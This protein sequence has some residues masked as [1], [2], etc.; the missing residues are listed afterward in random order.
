MKQTKLR[1]VLFVIGRM[2]RAALKKHAAVRRHAGN[3]QCVVQI[4]LKDGSIARYYEF[5]AG[6]V[7]SKAGIHPN[8]DVNM[9]FKDLDTA[10]TFLSPSVTQADIIHAAK[11]FRVMVLGPDELAVWFMQLMNLT[12]TASLQMGTP[13]P[14]GTTR[15]TTNTNGGPLFVYV[16]DD[17]IVR[18]TPIDLDD[19]DAA[20]WTIAARGKQ[21]TPKRRAMINPHAQCLKSLVYSEKRILYPMR[22]VD[23]DPNGERNPQN[24]GKSGYARISWKEALDIVGNEIKRQRQ[25]HGPG[26]IALWHGSHHQWGNVGYY[27]SALLRF[28]NL[29]GFTRVHHNPDSWEGWYWGAQHHYGNSLRVGIPGFYGLVEDCLKEAEMI[30]FWSSDPESTSGYASGLEGTQRRFWAKELGIEFV[31]IDPNLNP[32]AQLYGGRWIPIRPGT[33]PAL[34]IAIMNVWVNEDLYDK[35][36]V[37]ART[38]GFDQWCDYLTG[39]EDGIPKTPEWQEAETGVPAHVVRALARQWGK[40]KTYLAAGGLGAGFGGACRNA[41][42]TQWA[43]NMVMLMAMQGLGKPGVNF[44]NL[45]AGTPLDHNFWFPG[46]AEGGISGE[47]NWTAAAAHTYCRMPHV[48][49]VNPVKQMVPR[50]R[51]PDA[52]VDGHCTGY[53][54]DGFSQEAQFA[55]YEYPMPGY[56]KIHML[57]RY[58]TSTFGTISETGRYVDMFRHESVEMVVN[59]AIWM[60]GDAHFADIILPAC[61]SFERHDISEWGNSGGYIHHNTDQLNHRMVLFQHKCIEPLGESKSDYQIFLEILHRLGTG[62][63]FSEGC[64]E[65]DWAK[66]M[67]DASDLA[68]MTSFKDFV[69]KGY[70]VIP[71]ERE[72]L[73]SPTYFR[74]FA[75]DRH[76]DVPEPIPLP[77]QWSGDFAKGLQ[78]QSGKFEF[79]PSSLLRG[80]PDNP[81]RPAV[82]RYTP[83]WEGRRTLSLVGNYPVQMISTHSRYSFHTYGDGKD[84]TLNDIDDHRVRVDGHYYWVMRINPQDAAERKVR[85]H[86]LIRVYNDRGSV[87]CAAD[88]SPMIAPG[89]CKAYESSAEVD[90]F[91]DPRFGRVDRGGCVNLLTPRRPQ[92]KHTDGM[93]SNSCLVNFEPYQ[94]PAE[95]LLRA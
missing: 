57:Y 17:R 49:T 56:S 65:L 41:T 67:F 30:V 73:R 28:G 46:Y 89:V 54:W 69:R 22:R 64:S 40:K 21:F 26:S 66:R 85:H 94:L 76:K 18:M 44:G 80:D 25:V 84:S 83:S 53:L 51:L 43:R 71:A 23:F 55:P 95:E 19:T 82:N 9:V 63:M 13:M 90:L 31:H 58:G 38:T 29:V 91:M 75:E 62:A 78:T 10:L 93:G 12:Q 16:K 59:Q 35:E 5:H 70:Y 72:T 27:L 88:V 7:G 81:E 2:L 60:E 14:D 15:F 50:Q 1:I 92:V 42:G 52:I 3:R 45:Q 36:Y 11:N 4:G 48:L 61:T 33:D 20:S 32:T 8:P 87:I 24:R 47:L 6:K 77:S 74:W 37:A 39:K 86:E 79:V 34:A 68:K